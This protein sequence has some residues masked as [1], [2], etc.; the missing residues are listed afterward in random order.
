MFTIKLIDTNTQH[1]QYQEFDTFTVIGQS[2]SP[3]MFKQ[4]TSDF[5]CDKTRNNVSV[6][7]TGQNGDKTTNL[8]MSKGFIAYVMNSGGKTIEVIKADQYFTNKLN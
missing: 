1:T 7:I 5:I 2:T 8:Y 6:V 3:V 4:L